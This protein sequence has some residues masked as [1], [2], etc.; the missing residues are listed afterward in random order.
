MDTEVDGSNPA[1]VCCVHEQDIIRNASVDS[2][3]C[4][5]VARIQ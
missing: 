4:P 1:S 5:S 3:A 2:G